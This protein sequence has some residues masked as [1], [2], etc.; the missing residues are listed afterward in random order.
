MDVIFFSNQILASVCCHVSLI[1]PGA[2][3]ISSGGRCRYLQVIDLVFGVF[4]NLSFLTKAAGRHQ[5]TAVHLQA[6]SVEVWSCPNWVT[7]FK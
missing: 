1:C 6:P 4:A 3:R 5:A 7:C 2:F